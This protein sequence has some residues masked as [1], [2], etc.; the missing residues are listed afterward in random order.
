MKMYNYYKVRK[1]L[2]EACQSI[3]EGHR[4]MKRESEHQR[5]R[6]HHGRVFP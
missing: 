2:T 3:P 1:K 5:R 4:D 6:A